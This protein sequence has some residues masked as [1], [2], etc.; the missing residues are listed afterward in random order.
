MNQ[1][2]DAGQIPVHAVVMPL[3]PDRVGRWRWIDDD[4]NVVEF[5]VYEV[6]WTGHLCCWHEDIGFGVQDGNYAEDLYWT[7]DRLVGHVPAYRL[8][9]EGVFQLVV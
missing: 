4:A 3:F 1:K 9:D 2:T 7:D 6:P 8:E 5:D